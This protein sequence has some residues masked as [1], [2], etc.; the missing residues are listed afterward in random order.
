MGL[1]VNWVQAII[2][3]NPTDINGSTGCC[4][5]ACMDLNCN[6]YTSVK[7]EALCEPSCSKANFAP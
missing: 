5:P 2:Q 3:L 1:R 4:Q 7:G 6:L